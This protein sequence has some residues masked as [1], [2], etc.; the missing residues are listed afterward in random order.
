MTQLQKPALPMS[1]DAVVISDMIEGTL[2][3]MVCI[4]YIHP[5]IFYLPSNCMVVAS[6]HLNDWKLVK[7]HDGLRILEFKNPTSCE[8]YIRSNRINDYMQS[9]GLG[10]MIV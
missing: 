10:M 8:G 2:Y 1:V 9:V 3:T 5:S 7:T 4:S 6:K